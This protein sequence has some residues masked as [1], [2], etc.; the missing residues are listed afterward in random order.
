MDELKM[1]GLELPDLDDSDFEEKG[2]PDIADKRTDDPDSK[3]SYDYDD[4]GL[5]DIDMP[6]LSEMDGSATAPEATEKKT[7]P[8]A[9]K[10]AN[11]S[12]PQFDEMYPDIP[13]K[14]AAP[15]PAQPTAAQQKPAQSS[16]QSVNSGYQNTSS[17]Y[18]PTDSAKGTYSGTRSIDDIYAARN[19][20]DPEK[21]EKGKKRASFI[22][23][24]GCIL[25][26]I[27]ILSYL[28]AI[29]GGTAGLTDYLS[30]ILNIGLC[31]VTVMF[32]KGNENARTALTYMNVIDEVRGIIA[33]PSAIAAGSVLTA[34]GGGAIA[35]YLLFVS[36]VSLIVRGILIYFIAV[37]E[38]VAEYCKNR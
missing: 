13:L 14:S 26:G 31:I 23:I 34:L 20:I 10:T 16:Y 29:I 1:E 32:M 11:N 4:S 12:M 3:Y 35:G 22:G 30:L 27:N 19:A 36:I 21:F 37:D 17:V 28:G 9:A 6:V 18:T 15:K 2:F 5:D 33:L 7:E 38:N 24:G 8:T 25:Y